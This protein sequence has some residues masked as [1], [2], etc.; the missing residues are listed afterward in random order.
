LVLNTPNGIPLTNYKD[1]RND[2]YADPNGYFNDYYE[3]PYMTIDKSR[4]QDQFDYLTASLDLNY[5][6]TNWLGVQLRSSLNMDNNTTHYTKEAVHFSDYA[7]SIR[8]SIASSDLTGSVSDGSNFNQKWVNDFI[9]SASKDF[10]DYSVKLIAGATTKE[11]FQKTVDV[12]A[13]ALEIDNYYNIKN[14]VGDPSVLSS[15]YFRR[16]DVGFYGDLTL[17]YKQYL[18]L[19]ATGR[20]DMTSVLAA[21]NNSFF[22][23]GVDVSFIFSEAVPM[24]KQYLSY[25]KLRA[26]IAQVGTVQVS[27]YSMQN[28]YKLSDYNSLSDNSNTT[29]NVY[30]NSYNFPYGTTTGFTVSNTLNNPKLKPEM[31][32]SKEMGIE[33]GFLDNRITFNFTDYQVNTKD[34]TVPVQISSASGYSSAY[35]NTGE[36]QNNGLEFETKFVPFSKPDGVTWEIGLNYTYQTSKVVS[37]QD[38][39]KELFLGGYTDGTGAYAIVGQDYPSLKVIDFQRDPQG[40]V[41]VDGATGYPI[42]NTTAVNVGSVNPKHILGISTNVK[43]KNFNLGIVAEY[44]GGGLIWN[45]I[46]NQLNFT[47]TGWFS[48]TNGRQRFVFPN[49]VIKQGNTYVP[50]TNVVTSQGGVDFWTGAFNDVE[51]PYVT[52]SD[53]WKIREISLSYSAPQKYLPKLVK[54]ATVAFIARNVLTLLPKSNYYTD[55]EFNLSTGNS[56]GITDVNQTAPTRS[57]GFNIAVNF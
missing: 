45:N 9:L 11:S 53:F 13:N 27:P 12:A 31:T 22:Y 5:K 49:S 6:F 48:A 7:K 32:V 1:W 2:P 35:V 30:N 29:A 38:S 3:N 33:L 4:Q 8:K 40:R 16:R 39:T 50:N 19:H 43:Y 18:F 20:N 14:R 41:V 10:G 26:G 44:R 52:S 21:S 25:G 17:G 46:A 56:S 15:N 28:V 55:P 37:L 23:P 51:S 47:G 54:R 24:L 57:Y 34:Q 36:T 42:K